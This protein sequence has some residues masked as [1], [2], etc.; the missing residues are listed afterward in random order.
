MPAPFERHEDVSSALET[1][2]TWKAAMTALG[3]REWSAQR[4]ASASAF[5]TSASICSGVVDEP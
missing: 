3:W 1:G 5:A 2:A 4:P